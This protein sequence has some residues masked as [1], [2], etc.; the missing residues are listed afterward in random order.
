MILYR[1]EPYPLQMRNIMLLDDDK[2]GGVVYVNKNT[3]DQAIM[4]SSRLNGDPKRVLD[5]LKSP[6]TEAYR[7]ILGLKGLVDEMMSSMPKPLNMLAPF[8]VFCTQNQGME[9]KA[10]DRELAYGILHQ[11]SQLT[12][13][14]QIT[15]VPVEVRNNI[16][17]PTTILKSYQTSWDDLCSTLQ[18]KVVMS[19]AQPVVGNSVPVTTSAPAAAAPVIQTAPAVQTSPA[20]I[21]ASAPAPAENDMEARIRAFQEKMA[22]ESEEEEKA[23]KDK[24]AKRSSGSA[25][26]EEQPKPTTAK[27]AEEAPK[28]N[29][30]AEKDKANSVLDEFDV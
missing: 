26:V 15:L 21:A 9:W 28:D 14:N 3:Y 24:L 8:L 16:T 2:S 22:R 30:S 17:I 10:D 18:E 1:K 5:I 11:Y 6:K 23:L 12:D 27:V 7:A 29:S 13:F 20:P 25:K 4:L 19:Y